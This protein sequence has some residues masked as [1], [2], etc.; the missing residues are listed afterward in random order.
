MERKAHQPAICKRSKKLCESRYKGTGTF[1]QRME[2]QSMRSR[3]KRKN[4]RMALRDPDCTFR[5]K[6]TKAAKST[7]ART[8]QELSEG[9]ANR[10]ETT[11][12]ILKLR[13][14]QEKMSQ[15]TFRPKL[16]VDTKLAPQAESRLQILKAPHTYVRRMKRAAKMFQEQQ[17]RKAQDAELNEFAEC[18]FHPKI[19]DAR[20]M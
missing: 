11:R 3:E 20:A 7:R 15:L 14:D 5:P 8:V 18:T 13:T 12:R 4:Q 10:R 9:D 17:R 16:N 19:H 1:L 2:K 6:I